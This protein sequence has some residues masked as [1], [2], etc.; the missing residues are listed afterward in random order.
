MV[1][2]PGEINHKGYLAMLEEQE[3]RRQGKNTSVEGSRTNQ[4]DVVQTI[5]FRRFGT[6]GGNPTAVPSRPDR[7][8]ASLASSETEAILTTS[9]TSVS[10]DAN[11]HIAPL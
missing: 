4:C 7:R 2:L 5:R 9:C 6:F 1:R 10:I 3:R 8:A 11:G